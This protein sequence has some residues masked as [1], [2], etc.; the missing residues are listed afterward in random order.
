MGKSSSFD[1]NRALHEWRV[2]LADCSP[3]TRESLD[4]LE[5]H[6]RE[7]VARLCGIGL[8]EE[9]AWII[10]EKR[11]GKTNAL[12]KE[13]EKIQSP[14]SR[15]R[16]LIIQGAIGLGLLVGS[17]FAFAELALRPKAERMRTSLLLNSISAASSQF[18]ASMKRW[19]NSEFELVSNTA[20]VV[21]IS[22][23]PPWRDAWDRL[24]LYEPFTT[25][26]GFGRAVSHGRNSK[27]KGNGPDADIEARFP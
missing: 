16:R 23:S 25:N 24:I 6:L 20:A 9:E 22:P 13:F 27:P 5:L 2:K 3:M 10:A 1:L 21:F 7:S 26:S 11:F 12:G 19:P 14:S 8:S 15:K 17:L 4:E 18:H